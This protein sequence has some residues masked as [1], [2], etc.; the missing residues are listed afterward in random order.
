MIT[1]AINFYHEQLSQEPGFAQ[2][3]DLA[4]RGA[5]KERGLYFG[6][7]PLCVSLRP[8][9]Y[10]ADDWHYI[11]TQQEKLLRAFRRSHEVCL[12]DPAKRA[13]L[14]LHDFEEALLAE[15]NDGVIPWTSS[16]LD[17]FFIAETRSLRTVEYNAETPAGMGYGDELEHAFMDLEVMRRFQTRYHVR[18]MPTLPHLS[19]S[20]LRAWKDWGGA[21]V[22]NVAIL[23]WKEVPTLN[24]HEICRKFF[25]Q[26]GL[27][28]RLVDPRQL[29]FRE[30][31]LWFEDFRIDLVYKRVLFSELF[32]Q[33]GTENALVR[34]M[35]T[36]AA[37][38]TNSLSAKLL[39][40]KASLAFL[41]DERNAD[42]FTAEQHEAIALHIPWTRV[43]EE[44][45]TLYAG[46]EVDLIP[47]VAANKERFVLK[48]NDEYG[49]RGVVIGWECSDE[50]WADV[51]KQA[52]TQPYVVQERVQTLVRDF[53][54]L[55]SGQLEIS[56]L[57]VD[58][59]PYVF[60]G[61][62]VHGCLTRLSPQSL[63]NVTA[64]LGS[65]VPTLLIEKK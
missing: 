53:P 4:F 64:G 31:K 36:R 34:A 43:V 7:R 59:D 54:A 18:P 41:S 47:F 11:K 5:L 8:H 14:R 39:A 58:A 29:E 3:T 61:E 42:L 22:P 45:K 48:P 19:E 20:L 40:K 9:F 60:Y 63:L 16:R 52:L 26:N 30:G 49:G 62:T 55:V 10:F 12:A 57:Y 51:L 2:E 46:G 35:R 23:D 28:S 65:V 38:I 44:R 13:Q 25:G 32:E 17:N 15:D 1:E 37:L 50:G 6:P 33:L 21:G 27:P 56:S 24:E